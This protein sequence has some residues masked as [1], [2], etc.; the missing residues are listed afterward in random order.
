MA[1]AIVL[2]LTIACPS[3]VQADSSPVDAESLF[4]HRGVIR[5]GDTGTK[6]ELLQEVLELLDYDTG[7]ADG[8][9]GDLTRQ[10]VIQFQRDSNLAADG[11]VGPVTLNALSV[12]YHRLFP[13][14]SHTVGE[15][16]TLSDIAERYA[17]NISELVRLN[18]LQ[19]PDRI[20]AGQVLTLRRKDAANSSE[21]HDRAEASQGPIAETIKGDYPAPRYRICLTFNDGPDPSTTRPI[22]DILRHYGIKATFFLIGSKVDK[23]P[24]LARDIVVQGHTV[25]IHGYE[26]KVL[27]GLGTAA[28]QADLRKA[29]EAVEKA[30]GKRPHYYRPPRG[31]LDQVQ[32]SEAQELGMR[33]VMW[34][35]VGATDLSATTA[36]ELVDL[37][38]DSARDG[39]II[40][41]HEGPQL[42]V[43]ALPAIIENLGYRGFG[44]QNLSDQ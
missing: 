5:Y 31:I 9:F 15:G 32:V 40:L 19:D 4:S 34:T 27:A 35:N 24:D 25:G 38:L 11:I 14:D 30:T 43:E 20:F 10:A 36:Q 22:L 8:V 12:R 21:S 2:F 39:G 3:A 42:T 16:E 17:M 28:V 23:Y 44:F 41:L 33:V 7:G 18:N 37:I 13:P 29:A 26:H 6:V 1:A